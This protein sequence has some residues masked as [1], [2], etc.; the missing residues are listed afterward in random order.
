[1]IQ[2]I[3]GERQ[4]FIIDLESEKT[5]K[6]FDLTGFTEIQVCFKAGTTVIS[7]LESV[8]A[9]NVAVVGGPTNGQISAELAAVDSDTL[10]A[11]SGGQIE[12]IISFSAT[13]IQKTQILDAFAVLD[14]I[15]P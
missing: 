12:V 4:P 2:V 7:K 5:G 3:Q 9:D 6:P 11:T 13:N 8:P 14:K 15:C 10:A 1:M